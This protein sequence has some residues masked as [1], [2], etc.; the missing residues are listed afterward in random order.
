[1]PPYCIRRVAWPRDLTVHDL[2]AHFVPCSRI[3]N[4]GV[5]PQSVRPSFNIW[6]QET[7]RTARLPADKINGTQLGGKCQENSTVYLVHREPDWLW[8][9]FFDPNFIKLSN[10][11]EAIGSESRK[12]FYK[13]WASRVWEDGYPCAISDISASHAADNQSNGGNVDRG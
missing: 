9:R 2:A 8:L 6:T 4:D 12:D 3:A 13:P 5:R 1:M 10:D 11:I 7:F